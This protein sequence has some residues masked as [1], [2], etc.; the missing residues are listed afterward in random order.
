MYP[1]ELYERLDRLPFDCDDFTV[2]F[3]THNRGVWIQPKYS[4]YD[5]D[6]DLVFWTSENADWED[7]D[8]S[9]SDVKDML[10]ECDVD[11]RVFV[12]LGFEY[13]DYGFVEISYGR[14]L[15]ERFYINWK[16]RRVDIFIEDDGLTILENWLE[17][18]WHK[19]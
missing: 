10:D 11:T 6:G 17:Q 16:R 12:R 9:V 4:S 15:D 2:R 7:E 14:I 19:N 13:G 18:P 8:L 5:G 1:A 3:T